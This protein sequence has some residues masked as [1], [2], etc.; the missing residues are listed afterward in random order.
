MEILSEKE[1][2]RDM[3]D[4]CPEKEAK[5]FVKLYDYSLWLPQAYV[6]KG[7]IWVKKEKEKPH[8]QPFFT[9]SR[10][11]ETKE[12]GDGA[13]E[14]EALWTNRRVPD[15][16][17]ALV[18]LAIEDGEALDRNVYSAFAFN[19]HIPLENSDWECEVCLAGMVIANSF[20][21]S[22][23]TIVDIDQ[24]SD[25]S[26]R[27][28]LSAINA[29]RAGYIGEALGYLGYANPGHALA[30]KGIPLRVDFQ[31]EGFHGWGEYDLFIEEAL[32]IVEQLETAGL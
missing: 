27:N 23:D 20:K 10:E 25:G 3:P 13:A 31:Y 9:P 16:L 22:R 7:G 1:A 2:L 4:L 12:W 28:K 5:F 21:V 26:V 19:W 32:P 8:L 6:Q 15:K 14:Y 24:F 29:F 11:A 18:R 17:S 30:N